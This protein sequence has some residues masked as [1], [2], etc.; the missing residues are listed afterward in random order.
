[1]FEFSNISRAVKKKHSELRAQ[2]AKTSAVTPSFYCSFLN[3]LYMVDSCA[4]FE[5]KNLDSTSF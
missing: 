4:K 3:V 2:R 5:K 1:M